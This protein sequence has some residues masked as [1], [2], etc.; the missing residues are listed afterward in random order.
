MNEKTLGEDDDDYLEQ[1]EIDAEDEADEDDAKKEAERIAKKHAEDHPGEEP[2]FAENREPYEPPQVVTSPIPSMPTQPRARGPKRDPGW[3][4]INDEDLFIESRGVGDWSVWKRLGIK[5]QDMLYAL[6][7]QHDV[8]IAVETGVYA[9][10]SSRFLLE[11]VHAN[12]AESETPTAPVSVFSCDPLPTAMRETAESGVQG[13]PA[14]KFFHETSSLALPKIARMAP[15]WDLFLHDSDH[16][17]E[18]MVFE[19]EY[20][21]HLVRDGGLIVC[22][23]W[24]A[25]FEGSRAGNPHGAWEHFASQRALAWWPM[26]TAAV[27]IRTPEAVRLA[28]ADAFKAAV[29]TAVSELKRLQPSVTAQLA[30]FLR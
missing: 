22:D 12:A 1:V 11:A 4:R 6:A 28:P 5:F 25:T 9:G 17:L 15:A 30:G 29:R 18:C 3:D 23:D 24:N 7:R 8:R 14:W 26:G 19:L 2:P 10:V 21:W 20:A 16:R 13:R 27:A